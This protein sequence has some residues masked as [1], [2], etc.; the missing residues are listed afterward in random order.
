MI[1]QFDLE[2]F[3]AAGA[4]LNKAISRTAASLADQVLSDEIV[5]ATEKHML[6]LLE[7]ERLLLTARGVVSS[8]PPQAEAPW[9]PDD[10]GEWVEFDHKRPPPAGTR[11][12]LLCKFE[13][14]NKNYDGVV[15]VVGTHPT[16]LDTVAYKV[17][18]P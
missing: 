17:V 14:A 9:Y 7:Q 15:C 13:R 12:E 3:L 10:S 6:F 4:L 5:S 8:A 18:K 11:V 1:G 2:A 16:W